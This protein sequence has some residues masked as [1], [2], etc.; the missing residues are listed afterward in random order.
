MKYRI[1]ICFIVISWGINAQNVEFFFKNIP[2]EVLPT[3]S[4]YNRLELLEYHKANQKDTLI[5]RFNSTVELLTLD[6]Q[7]N[8][9]DVQLNSIKNLKILVVNLNDSTPILVLIHTVCAPICHSYIEFYNKKWKKIPIK[10]P[11]FT[12]KDFFV[13][14]PNNLNISTKMEFIEMS[15][16]PTKSFL[17]LK[18]NIL[19]CL[20]IN[21]KKRVEK[22]M[23]FQILKLDLI[24]LIQKQYLAN[25]KR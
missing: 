2:Q 8:Y 23:K 3:L 14:K 9:I 4:S 7:N 25:K 15:F 5:N 12:V 18:T 22:K 10:I 11:H 21:E 13:E 19:E 24:K 16:E 6:T 17:L 20:G 1:L